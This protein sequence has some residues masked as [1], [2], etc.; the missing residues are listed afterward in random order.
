M[1]WVPSGLSR[2]TLQN[3]DGQSTAPEEA[4]LPGAIEIPK[5]QDPMSLVT[6]ISQGLRCSLTP[7]NSYTPRISGSQ[8]PRITGSEKQ[9][10][11]EEF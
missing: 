7:R 9:L 1:A 5:P 4:A 3:L 8:D 11:S 6:P 2:S 10:H